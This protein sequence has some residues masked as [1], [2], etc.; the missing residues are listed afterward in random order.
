MPTNYETKTKAELKFLLQSRSLPCINRET[1]AIFVA[2]LRQHDADHPPQIVP[3]YDRA[4]SFPFFRLPLEIR[5]MVY[6]ELLTLKTPRR[7]YGAHPAWDPGYAHPQILSADR[8]IH[9][10]ASPLLYAFNTMKVWMFC[11]LVNFGVETVSIKIPER[12][13]NRRAPQPISPCLQLPLYL[14]KCQ[15]L[16]I[17][18]GISNF[19]VQETSDVFARQ[20]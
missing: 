6:R 15:N 10:E 19:L 4:G 5:T 11:N 18:L 13:R 7:R 2:R 20:L 1:K 9:Q 16:H 8:A 12:K 14:Y 3:P 17:W